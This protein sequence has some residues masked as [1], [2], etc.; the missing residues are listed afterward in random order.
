[1][2]DIKERTSPILIAIFV[3]LVGIG[4]WAIIFNNKHEHEEY[5]D[6]SEYEKTCIDMNGEVRLIPP[7][8]GGRAI[9]GDLI[10]Y[11]KGSQLPLSI[12]RNSQ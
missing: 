5:L 11:P 2:N 1:M 8:A 10:C 9:F 6:Y 12:K 4:I 3:F 7:A